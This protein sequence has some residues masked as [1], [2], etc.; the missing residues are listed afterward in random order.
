M[1]GGSLRV[2]AIGCV[3]GALLLFNSMIDQSFLENAPQPQGQS[4]VAGAD[5][6][7]ARREVVPP[8]SNSA[9][10]K[11]SGEG[12]RLAREGR[13][14]EAVDYYTAAL[15][16][17][18]GNAVLYGKRAA[19]HQQIGELALADRDRQCV[20]ALAEHPQ[21]QRP[22]SINLLLGDGLSISTPKDALVWGAGAWLLLTF[23]YCWIGYRQSR[24]GGGTIRRL[25]GV[26][27]GAAIIALLPLFA[28]MTVQL[29]AQVGFV[30][31]SGALVLTGLSGF[32]MAL[33][34]RPPLRPYGGRPPLPAVEDENVLEGVKKLAKA[35]G[36]APPRVRLVR[37]VGGAQRVLAW[38]GGLPQPTI[39]VTDGLLSRLDETER[40]AVIAHEMAHIANHS[41]WPLA[42]LFSVSCAVAVLVGIG[43]PLNV[44]IAFGFALLIGLRRVISRPIEADCDRRAARVIGFSNTI[45]ALKKIHALQPI[46]A[47]GWIPLIGYAWATHPSPEVRLTL[48]KRAAKREESE[49]SV[50]VPT[51]GIT[52][53]GRDRVEPADE[54]RRFRLHRAISWLGVFLWV[55]ALCLGLRLASISETAAFWLLIA[56]ACVPNL[57]LASARTPAARRARAQQRLRPAWLGFVILLGLLTIIFAPFFFDIVSG[58]NALDVAIFS[59]IVVAAVLVAVLSSSRRGQGIGRQIAEAMQDHRFGDIIEIGRRNRIQVAKIPVAR[60]NIAFIE[61]LHGDRAFAISELEDLRRKHRSF[62]L[63]TLTLCA[64]Y[65]EAGELETALEVAQSAARRW[66]KDPEFRLCEAKA[67]R[68]LGRLDEAQAASE[69]ALA[70]DPSLGNSHAVA[71][72]IAL[73]RGDVST[74]QRLV[75]RAVELEPGGLLALIVEAEIALASGDREESRAAIDRAVKTIKANPFALCDA[76]I[77]R[78]EERFAEL[79]AEK[80]AG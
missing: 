17:A 3:V 31:M 71:A 21:P 60:Y 49:T 62:A 28:W 22:I 47:T 39:L 13:F 59:P 43:P 53:E 4:D 68:G 1:N 74:A 2:L 45:A 20:A 12:D 30:E 25:V 40:D 64:L 27:G 65:Y 35:M 44:A 55:G 52:G 51:G 76:D 73:G 50:T 10:E 75:E 11:I 9:V 78:L 42:S 6:L 14:R 23:C 46:R 66:P 29:F 79:D 58:P 34:L 56:V 38:A 24:E 63:P 67:L 41:L 37:S 33:A 7:A 8:P 32:W 80:V 70:I 77:A 72:G 69:A 26:A 16:L 36:I 19:M 15:A 18:P 57:L 5:R 61:A 48:L 54:A